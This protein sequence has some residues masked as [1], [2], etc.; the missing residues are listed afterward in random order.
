MGK[1]A[2]RKRKR[3]FRERI[4]VMAKEARRRSW[5]SGSEWNNGYHLGVA[6]GL[7]RAL[8]ELP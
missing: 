1:K 3:M 5:Q 2:R 6:H 4:R 7:E 8:E